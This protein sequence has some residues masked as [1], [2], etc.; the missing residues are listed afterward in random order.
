MLLG[1]LIV[2]VWSGFSEAKEE[3]QPVPVIEVDMPSYNFKRV[4]QGDVVKHDFRV[5]NRGGATLEI[6]KVKPA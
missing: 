4:S 5:F 6:K 3:T 2:A 1:F